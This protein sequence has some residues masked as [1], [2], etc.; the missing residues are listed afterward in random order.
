[1]FQKQWDFLQ[2]RFKAGS[3]A[4]AYIFSG[5]DVAGKKLF[6]LRF[7]QLLHCQ[8]S[9]GGCGT[10]QHCSLIEKGSFVDVTSV[11]SAGSKSSLDNGIDSMEI[12]V[13]QIRQVQN[14]LSYKS[15]Y[16]GA[17]V[18][19]VH[20]AE[21]MSFEA[22]HCFLKTLEEPKGNTLLILLCRR[23]ELLLQTIASRCQELK[24]S[25]PATVVAAVQGNPQVRELL[26]LVGADLAEKFAFA[27]KADL[28]GEQF[29]AMLAALQGY[30]RD[31]LLHKVG[32]LK[33]PPAAAKEFTVGQLKKIIRLID[34]MLQQMLTSNA[35]PKIALEI[36]L[37][38]I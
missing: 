7:A 9:T 33:K 25:G 16:G 38:E 1:M 28:Q 34:A 4:H 17:K 3:L 31:I 15:Y 21:R 30:F 11:A 13:S 29:A 27:K 10:C 5:E 24:F 23:P 8:N 36:L 14:F 20:D 18:V 32:V 12:D 37:L 22:Q 2:K 19:I 26:S 6:A 35:S